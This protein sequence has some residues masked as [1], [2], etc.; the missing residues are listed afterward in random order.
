MSFCNLIAWVP[1]LAELT[2]RICVFPRLLF[3]LECICF[4]YVEFDLELTHSIAGFQVKSWITMSSMTELLWTW[5]WMANMLSTWL[6]ADSLSYREN[7]C[8]NFPRNH[9]VYISSFVLVLFVSVIFTTESMLFRRQTKGQNDSIWSNKVTN[10]PKLS[11]IQEF[12][13]ESEGLRGQRDFQVIIA[14]KNVCANIYSYLKLKPAS[15]M[16]LISFLLLF[17]FTFALLF[18]TH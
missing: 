10:V 17:I 15:E 7:S 14:I 6:D 1:F 13:A 16:Q 8:R 18:I 5:W 9:I 12:S 2:V 3:I 4:L 11:F